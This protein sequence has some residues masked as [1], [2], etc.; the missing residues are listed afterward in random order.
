MYHTISDNFKY[1]YISINNLLFE[2]AIQTLYTN[3]ISRIMNHIVSLDLATN[4]YLKK[5]S[6][7]WVLRGLTNIK[8]FIT[9][10]KN[11]LLGSLD[12]E[13]PSYIKN[14]KCIQALTDR[15]KMVRS[16]KITT[17]FSNVWHFTRE[18]ISGP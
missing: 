3:D 10:M 2:K 17:A 5:P 12:G 18:L 4:F 11:V 8:Y 16:M 13:L 14:L 15:E 6:S 7:G 9:D 1:H